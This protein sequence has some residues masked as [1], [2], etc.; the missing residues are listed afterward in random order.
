MK[1]ETFKVRGRTSLQSEWYGDELNK[2]AFE[3]GKKVIDEAQASMVKNY[4]RRINR[5]SHRRGELAEGF[6][7]PV[8]VRDKAPNVYYR[9]W[10]VSAAPHAK[11]VEYAGKVE[12]GKGIARSV[13]RSARVKANKLFRERVKKVIQSKLKRIR[14]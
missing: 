12:G 7:V 10:Q 1:K 8:D 14:R 6:D 5:R 13:R 9:E 3:E 2:F 11:V 4:N